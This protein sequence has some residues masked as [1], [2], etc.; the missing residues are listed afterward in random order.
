MS[1]VFGNSASGSDF[2][3][4]SRSS[5]TYGFTD[6]NVCG[7][8]ASCVVYRM[9][10]GG[11]RVAVKRLKSEY[12]NHPTYI[13]A[14]QKEF[15]I[16]RQ[17]KHDALPI[18]REFHEDKDELYI[19]MDY[20]D[21]ISLEEFI[22]T[23]SGQEYFSSEDNI[24]RFLSE[25]LN[26]TVYLHRSG[27]IHCDLKP[28]NIILRHSDRG[29]MLIDLDKAYCDTLDR[30]HGGTVNMSDPLP[31]DNK[32]T[33]YKDYR[34][35][36]RIVDEIARQ[37]PHFP[38]SEFKK[39]IATCYQD[40]ITAEQLQRLLKP[41]SGKKWWIIV[42]VCI[43][44]TTLTFLL[45][46]KQETYVSETPIANKDTVIIQTPVQ[47]VDATAEAP[48][49][50]Q[51]PQIDFDGK[52][53]AFII[54]AD[55]AMFCLHSGTLTNP[56]INDIVLSITEKYTSAY[57]DIVSNYKKQYPAVSGIDIE[58][59]VGRASERSRSLRLLQQFT[60]EAADTIQGRQPHQ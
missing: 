23:K 46:R 13:A 51:S 17:L 28:A 54:S 9:H 52:M 39:F 53:A 34:A 44:A 19:V 6:A 15:Q 49:V 8:S 56:E 31:A 4:D 57:G 26:V 1:S 42:A 40:G 22:G 30:T 58:L 11:L 50:P 38:R 59:A 60:Q 47:S 48:G 43:I 12:R 37:V 29:V 27:V 45:N 36:G 33:A 3:D 25:L 16:G 18:Y 5:I 14:Y 7:E 2:S 20:V 32:P 55:S 21:G 35:I 24:R 41:S 10:L